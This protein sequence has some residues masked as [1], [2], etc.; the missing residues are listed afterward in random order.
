MDIGE[1]TKTL[2]GLY[3]GLSFILSGV[4]YYLF[5]TAKVAYFA[6]NIWLG[7]L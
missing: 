2:S 7:C 4:T 3:H 6:P 1:H 5:L